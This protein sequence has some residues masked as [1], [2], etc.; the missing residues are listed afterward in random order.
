M[1]LPKG[2]KKWLLVKQGYA[3]WPSVAGPQAVRVVLVRDPEGQWRDERLVSTNTHLSSWEMIWG[4]CRRWCVEITFAETKGLLG[5]H[6]PCVWKKES[7]ERAA[8]MA[9]YTAM[10]VIMWYVIEGQHEER[11][12]QRHRPWYN[13][14]NITFSDMLYSLRLNL[15][16]KWRSER[17]DKNPGSMAWEEWLLEYLATST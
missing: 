2:T 1:D 16:R 11:P 3:Y 17:G 13:K 6:D 12:A 4:Y 5:F 14:E 7:V 15:W 10:L 9:W 8:P